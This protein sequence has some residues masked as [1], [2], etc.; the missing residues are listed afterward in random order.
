ME[1]IAHRGF[2]NEHSPKNSEESFVQAWDNAF[3]IE[4]D[5]RD[6]GDT[7]VISH[8]IPNATCMKLSDFF[9]KYCA[10]DTLTTLALNIKADGL[11]YLLR[12]SL[13]RYQIENYFVF[14]MSLPDTLTYRKLGLD[15]YTRQSEYEPHP[16]LYDEAKGVWLDEFSHHWISSNTIKSHIHKNKEVCIVSPELH[17]RSYEEE[18]KEYKMIEKEGG[19]DKIKL[20]TDYP[21]QAGSF[22]CD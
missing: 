4:T 10:Y 12:E 21:E 7:L 1:I 22:F 16:Y 15:F 5:I 20:C 8:D 13:E 9:E 14:D 11:Q 19:C 6:F 2:W 3:G 17:G 18:W